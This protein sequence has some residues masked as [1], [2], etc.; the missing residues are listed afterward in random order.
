MSHVGYRIHRA[1]FALVLLGCVSAQAAAQQAPQQRQH[2]VRRGDTLWDLSGSYLGN[3][4]LWPM[5]YEANR[6]VVED[7]HWIYPLEVLVIPPITPVSARAPVGDPL[8]APLGEGERPRGVVAA[9]PEPAA[10]E[11]AA[12]LA[13]VDLRRPVIPPAEYRATP[14]LS[15]S[16]ESLVRGRLVALGD[17]SEAQNTLPATLHPNYRVHLGQL[18]GPAP[19]PGDSMLVVRFGRQVAGFGQVVEPLAMLRIEEASGNTVQA[20]VARQ[21]GEARVGDRVIA[22]DAMP[23]IPRGTLRSLPDGAQGSLLE[24]LLP[25]PIYGTGEHAFVSLG[26]GRVQL[27]DELAIYVPSRRPD[28]ATGS[29][30]PP[31][32]IARARVVRV[33]D[34]SATVRLTKV[35]D[36]S[37][38]DG[39]PVRVVGR[40]P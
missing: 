16:T 3:P 2:T 33:T 20:S 38:E 9:A 30:V 14:W 7:P 39:L 21:F 25:Q 4:F 1:L 15:P 26:Q 8:G 34:R 17:P 13:T 12:E 11:A 40:A 23:A 36:S 35:T 5:I 19:Q 10:G 22:V 31:T 24:F 27:G 18:R 29:V 6:N 28:V 32:E 37:L